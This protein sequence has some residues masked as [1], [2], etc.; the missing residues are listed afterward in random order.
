MTSKSFSISLSVRAAVGSS[1]ISIFAF[2][3]SA[4]AISTICC[5]A[6]LKFITFSS[7][8]IFNPS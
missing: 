1:I 2:V 4:F 5:S 7:G 8:N 6:T 3:E